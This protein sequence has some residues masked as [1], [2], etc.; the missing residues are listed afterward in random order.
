MEGVVAPRL[1]S[2]QWCVSDVT[3]E[4][5][6]R[7]QMIAEQQ[8]HATSKAAVAPATTLQPGNN[9]PQL[10]ADLHMHI[11][12]DII[13]LLLL[14]THRLRIQLYVIVCTVYI[15]MRQR[16]TM[17][18]YTCVVYTLRS[19]FFGALGYIFSFIFHIVIALAQASL[20]TNHN[21]LY[22]HHGAYYILGESVI[23]TKIMCI[24]KTYICIFIR[25][26]WEPLREKRV[27]LS[28]SDS[29][30]IH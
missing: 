18:I 8:S 2:V 12:R 21:R 30:V 22:T 16:M 29:V 28:K 11:L 1:K 13:L 15:Y 25:V 17:Y 3:E 26:E 5:A 6:K 19:P 27:L 9:P 4:A 24:S 14:N 20:D 10:D 7:A 23:H